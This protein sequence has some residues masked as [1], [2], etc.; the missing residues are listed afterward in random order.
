MRIL[1]FTQFQ[2]LES[3]DLYK[4][5]RMKLTD[6]QETAILTVKLIE[7]GYG[8]NRSIL[9]DRFRVLE[10]NSKKYPIGAEFIFPLDFNN[11]VFT[12]LIYPY[13]NEDGYR[14]MTELKYKAHCEII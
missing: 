14:A 12:F 5:V 6:S 11:K 7:Q 1:N 4:T 3:I 8:L 13:Y 9:F 2:V 10:S